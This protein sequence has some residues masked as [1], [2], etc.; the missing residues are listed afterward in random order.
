VNPKQLA[1]YSAL[2]L[3]LTTALLFGATSIVRVFMGPSAVSRA[4][5][6]VALP[7]VSYAVL[8]PAAWLTAGVAAAVW[9]RNRI[10]T[11]ALLAHR[12]RGTI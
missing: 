7:P 8:Q 12:L 9:V 2:E 5:P 4:I 6:D 1:A 10:Q 3:V 11:D